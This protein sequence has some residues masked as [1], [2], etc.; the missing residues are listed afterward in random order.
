MNT[1][2]ASGNAVW[3]RSARWQRVGAELD[4][5]VWDVSPR[6]GAEQQPGARADQARNLGGVEQPLCRIPMSKYTSGSD[7]LQTPS[8][9]L[10]RALDRPGSCR[11]GSMLKTKIGRATGG[12]YR[13]SPNPVQGVRTAPPA[14]GAPGGIAPGLTKDRRREVDLGAD[15][16]EERPGARL[17]SRGSRASSPGSRRR[18]G[19]K[20]WCRGRGG[21]GR[22]SPARSR[23]AAS[24]LRSNAASR[25]FPSSRRGQ[26]GSRFRRRG[27]AG[28]SRR[29]ALSCDLQGESEG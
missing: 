21:N 19:S 15:L 18:S 14:P 23:S 22:K 2:D 4:R 5:Q 8:I 9:W 26:R 25:P 3:N 27:P 6:R 11:S 12:R 1:Q 10:S 24:G 16:E 17:D 7:R 13:S 28:K 29:A 20:P